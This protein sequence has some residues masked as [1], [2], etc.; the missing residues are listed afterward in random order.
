MELFKRG[1][2]DSDINSSSHPA[3]SPVVDLLN[4]QKKGLMSEDEVNRQI[5]ALRN[6]DAKD[7]YRRYMYLPSEKDS[8][9]K[10]CRRSTKIF[11]DI[12]N[13]YDDNKGNLERNIPEPIFAFRIHGDR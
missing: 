9:F 12:R 2:Y 8:T 1:Y 10:H 4:K 5:G 3:L 11:V 7:Q 6:I 13:G